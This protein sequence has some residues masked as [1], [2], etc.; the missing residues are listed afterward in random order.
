[1]PHDDRKSCWDLLTHVLRT[2][3]ADLSQVDVGHHVK[4]AQLQLSAEPLDIQVEHCDLLTSWHT[5]QLNRQLKGKGKKVVRI[6]N[7][8]N[9]SQGNTSKNKPQNTY[10]ILSKWKKIQVPVIQNR[11][12][13]T[14]REELVYHRNSH[15]GACL[16]N[17]IFQSLQ[18]CTCTWLIQISVS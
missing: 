9:K 7:I 15:E 14:M 5:T 11:Q 17:K 2:L 8:N 3:Q 6:N 18:L 4:G 12:M 10:N 1:M 13:K 16:Y